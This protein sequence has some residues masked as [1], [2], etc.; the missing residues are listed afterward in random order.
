MLLDEI[1]KAH[2][3][4]FDLLLG[5]LGEGRLTDAD[6]RLVDFRMTICVMTSNI[7]VQAHAAAGFGDASDGA[8]DLLRAVRSHF[9]PEFF[10]R[11]DH[12]IPFGSLSPEHIRRIVDLELAQVAQRTGLVRRRLRLRVEPDARAW[13]A[14]RGW[15]PTKGARPLKR[16]IEERLVAPVA[17]LLAEQPRLQDCEL[18]VCTA[19]VPVAARAGRVVLVID[20]AHPA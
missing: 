8:E 5:M 3:E 11:I 14:E 18:V 15:H 20:D 12:V 7:G 16:V 6:G 2:P 4:V 13:L 10:N 9:R 17:A 1:E 19:G